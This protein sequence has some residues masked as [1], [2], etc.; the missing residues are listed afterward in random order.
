MLLIHLPFSSNPTT[1]TGSKKLL[2]PINSAF[3][4][5]SDTVHPI[6][7]FIADQTTARAKFW[8]K[9]S[10]LMFINGIGLFQ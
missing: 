7:F 8:A 5:D 10:F 9:G 2:T 4:P 3:A 1:E 6:I